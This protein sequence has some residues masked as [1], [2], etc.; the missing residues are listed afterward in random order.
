VFAAILPCSRIYNYAS[1]IRSVFRRL[2]TP[3]SVLI[4]ANRLRIER[5]MSC[6]HK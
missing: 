6:Y 1:W 4:L 5:T 2:S 3:G